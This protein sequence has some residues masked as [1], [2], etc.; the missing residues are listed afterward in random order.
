MKIKVNFVRKVVFFDKE[1]NPLYTKE[2]K[3]SVQSN[4]VIIKKEIERFNYLLD[5]I[6]GNYP[7]FDLKNYKSPYTNPQ[8]VYLNGTQ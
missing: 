2:K 6:E 3:I 7:E 8:E 5:T 4:P 1:K